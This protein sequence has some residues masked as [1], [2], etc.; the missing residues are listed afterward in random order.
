ME[1][2][3]MQP[4]DRFRNLS[5]GGGGWGNPL[6]RPIELVR[7][8][9]LDEYVSVEQAERVYGVKLEEDGTATATGAR[10]DRPLS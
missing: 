4:R 2:F 6:D 7:E 8:D 10:L 5:A 3:T 1:R 9:V